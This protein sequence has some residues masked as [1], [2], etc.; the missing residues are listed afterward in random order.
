MPLLPVRQRGM[1]LILVLLVV[2]LVVGL[3]VKYASQFQL[4]MAR[5][6]SRWASTG[7]IFIDGR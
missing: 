2:A 4:G 3:S 5:A 7:Q 6:E 1:V